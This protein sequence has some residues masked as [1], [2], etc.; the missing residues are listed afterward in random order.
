[1]TC[2]FSAP[3]EGQRII[4]FWDSRDSL[5]LE[6]LAVKPDNSNDEFQVSVDDDTVTAECIIR[7]AQVKYTGCQVTDIIE[8]L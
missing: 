1:M 5:Q 7:G 4:H 2:D 3:S 6:A 8:F